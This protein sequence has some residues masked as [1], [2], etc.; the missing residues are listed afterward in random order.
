MKR[1]INP[2][3]RTT[4]L[5]RD[6]KTVCPF[7]HSPLADNDSEN[8][9]NSQDILNSP[10]VR[11]PH[12]APRPPVSGSTPLLRPADLLTIRE[13][14]EEDIPFM[15]RKRRNV[16]CHGQV[17][18]IGH[19]ELFGTKHQKL[20]NAIFRGEPYQLSHQT[21]EYTI[22]V[23]SI[24]SG[25][26]GQVTDFC[27]YG[28]YL[29]R[30]QPGDEVTIWARD[31]GERRVARTIYNHTTDSYVEPGLQI[32]AGLIKG[33]LLI[34]VLLIVWF[35]CSIVSW[36]RSGVITDW[37]YAMFMSL[38]PIVLILAGIW[39]TIRSVLPRRRR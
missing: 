7:C 26:P 27:L 6:D 35:L 1:C 4:F 17:V 20:M 32:P 31:L 30:F 11:T 15:K 24:S 33:V 29:N 21:I 9:V 12:D 39:W 38:M 14:E 3:C 13:P 36:V 19:H 34:L 16:E 2:E 25:Y 23:E 22:R 10:A 18:E 37:L 5:F 8:A 28:N